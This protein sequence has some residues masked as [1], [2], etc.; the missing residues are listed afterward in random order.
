MLP[1]GR[2]LMSAL[3]ALPNPAEME[4]PISSSR[5]SAPAG[6]C[7]YK[8]EQCH[9]RQTHAGQQPANSK[10]DWQWAFVTVR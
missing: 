7:S 5:R 9:D 3:H 6:G 10:T 2:P 8:R 1:T 4:S